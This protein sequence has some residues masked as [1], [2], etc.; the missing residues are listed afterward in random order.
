MYVCLMAFFQ[1]CVSDQPETSVPVL[2]RPKPILRQTLKVT[3]PE[4]IPALI[5]AVYMR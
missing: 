5:I 4:L 2:S 1:V 3:Y